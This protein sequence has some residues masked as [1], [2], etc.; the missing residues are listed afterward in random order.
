MKRLTFFSLILSLPTALLADVSPPKSRFDDNKGGGKAGITIPTEAPVEV[1]GEADFLKSLKQGVQ[2]TQMGNM[3]AAFAFDEGAVDLE[4]RVTEA[5]SNADFRVF[6]KAELVKGRIDPEQFHKIGNDRLSDLVVFTKLTLKDKPALGAMLLKE[7][8]VTIQV[9]NPMSKELLVSHTVT[10]AGQRHP[11][12]DSAATT[13][14]EAAADAAVPEVIAKT[15]EKAHKILVHEAQL[16]GVKDH[17]HL[18]EIMEY[19][20]HLDG[21]YHVRQ[22]SY[23]KTSQLAIIEIIA[24]PKT[25]VFWRA[26]VEAMPK[27]VDWQID[28]K[29]QKIILREK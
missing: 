19:T 22:V 23:D 18:L 1:R 29:H 4:T 8:T 7:A 17:A 25:E 9:Y 20:A 11:D 27:R 14:M 24:A 15:L 6:P 26:Y 16:K 3:R 10:K 28:I 5:F 13:S 2:I 12:A 21:V